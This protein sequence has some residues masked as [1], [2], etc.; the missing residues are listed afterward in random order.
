MRNGGRTL[1]V[2][3]LPSPVTSLSFLPLHV[4]LFVAGPFVFVFLVIV[5][6]FIGVVS[7][8]ELAADKGL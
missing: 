6:L 3:P 4:R 2:H 5:V 7:I 8:W 1:Y